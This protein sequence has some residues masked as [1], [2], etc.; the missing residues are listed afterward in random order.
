MT[1]SR[2]NALA[3]QEAPQADVLPDYC[4]HWLYKFMSKQ[5][6]KDQIHKKDDNTRQ[7][8]TC[9]CERY[10]QITFWRQTLDIN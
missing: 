7:L 5:L 3:R 9:R 1:E 2:F 6:G 10:G 8:N 4:M